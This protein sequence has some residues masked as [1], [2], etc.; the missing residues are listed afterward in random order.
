MKSIE[1]ARLISSKGSK[2]G[3]LKKTIQ[4]KPKTPQQFR[5]FS[6]ELYQDPEVV[7]LIAKSGI[8]PLTFDELQRRTTKIQQL[9]ARQNAIQNQLK[10][11]RQTGDQ[12]SA[13]PHNL[14]LHRQK[15]R[16]TKQ[17]R[18]ILNPSLPLQKKTST[19]RGSF[20]DLLL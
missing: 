8:S 6:T 16:L 14:R 4:T 7:Q 9:K 13:F 17:I 1:D 3:K 19:R 2:V 10:Q 20:A 15:T 12:V 5:Q 11:L 18:Q